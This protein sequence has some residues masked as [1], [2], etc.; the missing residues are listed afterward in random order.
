MAQATAPLPVSAP[1][2]RV[3]SFRKGL[4]KYWMDYL[5]I[6]PFFI[7]F[8]V[9]SLYPLGWALQLSFSRWRGFGPMQYVGFDNYFAMF[10]DPFVIQSFV[11]TMQFYLI[12]L[13]TGVL[14][15]I[16]LAVLLNIKTL[17]GRGIFRT[18]YFLPFVTSNVIIAM[19]FSQLFDDTLGWVN[20]GLEVLGIPTVA[21][22]RGSPWG[23]KVAVILLTHWGG[24]G[25]NVL[26]F[27][28]G[29]QGIEPEIYEAAKIDGANEWQIFGRITLPLLRPIVLFLTVIATIGLINMFNQIF[30]LTRGGPEGETRTLMYRLYEI[31]FTMG[32][33][34]GDAAAFGFLIG[35]IVIIISMLQLRFFGL[36]RD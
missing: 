35:I 30:M 6:A 23:A 27:L 28:G 3:Q 36:N 26:L 7:S 31:G 10:K 34:Y 24:M 32:G 1:P 20:Q 4:S 11:N 19:V 5:F 29:L 12:L 9:F 21:W 25:Y 13:P 33:R 16:G 15:A 8:A 17:P 22:L 2:S 14:A 18:I